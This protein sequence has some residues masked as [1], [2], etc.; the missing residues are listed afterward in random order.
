M[1]HPWAIVVGVL[2]V[3]LPVLIHWLTRPRP[4]RLPISTLRFI[5]DVIRQRRSVHRLRDAIILGLRAMAVL[6]LA[7][8]IARPLWGQRGK[9]LVTAE[10]GGDT[11][12]VVVLDVSESMSAREQSIEV[13]E[14]AR[15]AAAEFLAYAQGLRAN[16]ILAGARPRAIFE[17]PSANVAALRDE[18]AKTQP[19][20]ERLNFQAALV[21]AAQ[22]LAQGTEAGVQKRELVVV[23]DFQKTSW[24]EADFR[25]MPPGTLIQMESVAPASGLGN[26]AVLGVSTQGRAERGAE[27]KV[28][29]EI[30]N[31]SPTPRQVQ[32]EIAIAGLTYR[33]SGLCPAFGR[34]VL[35]SN[36]VP[37]ADGWQA[38]EVRLVD[39]DDA[40]PADNARS[41]VLDVR[42]PTTYALVSRQRNAVDSSASYYLE[43]ALVPVRPREGRNGERVVRIDPAQ[44]DMDS[45]ASADLVVVAHP[46]KLPNKTVEALA[47]YV[48]RGRSIL[49]AAAETADAANL[50]LLTEAIGKDLH[51]PVEFM[52]PAAGRPRRDLKLAN[53]RRDAPAFGLFGDTLSAAVAPLRFAGG[54]DTRA[55][56]GGL[57]DDVWASYGNG[58]A[59][60]AVVRQG[61]AFLAVINADLAASNLPA[62][63][64]FVPLIQELSASLLGSKNGGHELPC[65]EPASVTLPVEIAT[66]AD[67]RVVP[68][69]GAG[70]PGALA[71]ESGGV[72]YRSPALGGPGVFQIKRGETTC[73]AFASA[74][75]AAES[76]LRCLDVASIKKDFASAG[77]IDVRSATDEEDARDSLW[78][79]LAVACIGCLLLE[80]VALKVLRT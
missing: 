27:I 76:D 35:S 52:P 51:M 63:P 18:L 61:E 32:V 1:L 19:R 30:G 4:V 28:D 45:I 21:M 41:F 53:V 10:S 37:A 60:L 80:L 44:L 14:K 70:E 65:G 20:P 34:T 25:S 71:T 17:R 78:V 12:R 5:Q 55:I 46:G 49:Y 31:F 33:A 16:L 38:G 3:G 6:L 7:W 62:S 56:E 8:A 48:R 57:A 47:S 13:F 42:A 26:L 58:S 36:A 24:A 54:L 77:K 43:R 79:W 68:P 29:A 23:S 40:L 66:H 74:I 2:A 72:A 73:L 39:V 69:A 22:M 59:F 15:P 11:L 64:V 75:P 50:K 67:L 9:P